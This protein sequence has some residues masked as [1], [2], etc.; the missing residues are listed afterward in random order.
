ERVNIHMKRFSIL[1]IIRG[2]K[3]KTTMR[4]HLTSIRRAKIKNT[5]NNKCWQL[6]GEK[7]TLLNCW[8][9]CKLVQPLW[10]KVWGFLKKLKI[11]LSYGLVILLLSIYPEKTKIL[12][13]KDTCTPVFIVAL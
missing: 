13:L 5:T 7:G 8:W 6:R 4:Y 11:K 10:K 2:M 9:E 12:L 3:I 1:L